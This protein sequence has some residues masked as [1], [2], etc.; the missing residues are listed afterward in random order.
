LKEKKEKSLQMMKS[1][2]GI[3][4]PIEKI[5]NMDHIRFRFGRFT[6]SNYEKFK[7]YVLDT[8]ASIFIESGNDE[9]YTYGVYFTPVQALRRVD[10]L[11]I[12]MNWERIFVPNEEDYIGTPKEIIKNLQQ[13]IK[14]IET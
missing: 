3:D 12:S 2:K 5:L 9:D 7:M 8:S 10:A 6:H 4:Y 1:F 13:E 11:Y 14:E